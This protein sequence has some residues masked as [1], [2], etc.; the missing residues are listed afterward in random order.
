MV[1]ILITGN[2]D[3]QKSVLS[4]REI[5]ARGFSLSFAGEGSFVSA[6]PDSAF[7]LYETG[8]LNQVKAENTIILCKDHFKPQKA[9]L[10]ASAIGV[11]S[12]DNAEAAAFI[13]SAGIKALVFG[14]SRKDTLTLSSIT[15][16]SA[17]LC[18]QRGVSDLAGNLIDPV[19]IPINLA[20]GYDAAAILYTAAVLILSGKIADIAKISF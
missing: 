2:D 7:F 16:D 4:F 20:R 15:P 13:Q 6:G 11:L 14:M 17:V 5:L 1:T 9:K 19:E 3:R 8:Q 18:L 10:P 12:S